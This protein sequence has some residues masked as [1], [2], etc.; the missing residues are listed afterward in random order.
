MLMNRII[1]AFTFRK[2]VYAE[3]ERDVE[4]TNTAWLLVVVISAINQLGQLPVYGFG[5]IGQ[6]LIASIVAIILSVGGF[7]LG[8]F[9]ISWIG[10]QFFKAE[11]DFGEM[12][13][14]L[15]LAY[16]WNVVGVIG[17]LGFIPFLACI[18]AP[19]AFIAAIAGLVAWLFAAKEALD[20]DWGPTAI[21]VIIGVIANV[22]ITMVLSG[23]I[24]GILGVGAAAAGAFQ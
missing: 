21:I 16:V 24:L 22:I 7:A 23:I 11:V 19:I 18:L 8:A 15:G 5:A 12:V 13:R 9:L 3:V 6:W 17:I 2:E 1:G 10:K 14:V 4:F 20:L